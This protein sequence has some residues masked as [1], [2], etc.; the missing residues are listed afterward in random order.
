MLP[1]AGAIQEMEVKTLNRRNAQRG[2]DTVEP[3]Y[4]KADAEPCLSQFVLVALGTW[5]AVAP[6]IRAR[7][8]NAGHILGSASIEVEV[9]DGDT[10]ENPVV[11]GDLGPGGREF[12][13]DPEGPQGGIT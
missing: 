6:G 8:C 2:R 11:L 7:W 5:L 4:T 9:V 3:I 13:D 10:T 1:D 12:A